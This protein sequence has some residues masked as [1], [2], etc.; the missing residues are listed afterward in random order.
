M[1]NLLVICLGT[2]DAKAR[3]GLGPQDIA[4]GVA[5]L[6]TDAAALDVVDQSLV[7]CPPPVR[8]VGDLAE[9]FTGA[10]AR[11]ERLPEQMERFAR[12]NGAH[13]IDAGQLIAVDPLDGVHWSAES[14]GKL[15]FAV[16]ETVREI[17]Q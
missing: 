5:R 8:E 9:V 3:F 1:T 15:G 2:N 16:A 11:M 6:L 13:F 14:H 7:I 12:E 4:L 17:F 10:A